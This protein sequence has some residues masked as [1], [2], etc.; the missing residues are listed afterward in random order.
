[1]SAI[2][3]IRT[4]IARL[5][6]PKAAPRTGQR[7][8]HA[9]ATDRLTFGW[10]APNNS[11]DSELA[12]SLRQ[13]RG[14]SRAAMRDIPYAKRA[15]VVVVNNVIGAGVGMQ[16]NIRTADG[17][18][19]KS[20]ND[21]IEAAWHK[22]VR[23]DSCH[24]GG[25]LHFSDLERAAMGQVFESGEVFIRL[26]VR[27]F[28][29][30][31]VPLALELIEAERIADDFSQ[32]IGANGENQVRMGVEVDTFGRAVAYWI[33]EHHPSEIRYAIN[34]TDKMIRVPADQIIHLRIVDRWPQTRG[35]P[36]LHA[37][38]RRLNDMEGYSE[39]EIVAARGAA[40][41]MAFIKTPDNS[42]IP[43][44]GQIEDQRVIDMSPGIVEQLPPGWDVVMNNPNRPNPNMDPF[45]RLMLREVAAGVGVSYESLSR[46]Y[47]QSNYSSSR[48]AL[49]DDRDLWRTLQQWWIRAFREPL[50]RAW[51]RQAVLAGAVGSVTI[52]AYLNRAEHYE[53]VK[54]KPRGWNWVDPT[55][56]VEAYRQAVLSGFM[57]VSD[58]IAQTGNGRDLEDVL[59]ERASELELMEDLDLEFD[60]EYTDP[61]DLVQPATAAPAPAEPAE[62]DDTEDPAASPARLRKVI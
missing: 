26:H 32:P 23:A 59:Q 28:G 52:D 53:Q 36:W 51:L 44:D 46:D 38:M 31:A 49:L 1:M 22:W 58:V 10:R 33:R 18:L 19:Q 11:A 40:A 37:T 20:A 43:V 6:S 41:Y 39:A 15:R 60:T 50:H 25:A 13:M 2:D 3:N 57:T 27:Q 35:E 47:S 21:G 29:A 61:A 62:P 12:S 45:M 14:R 54:F 30:S 56:E 4:R 24:T 9:A 5:I 55:R 8:Y 34:A 48:L 7:L 17:K 42:P 16:G